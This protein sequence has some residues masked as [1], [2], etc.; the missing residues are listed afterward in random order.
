MQQE[1]D[2]LVQNFVAHRVDRTAE[3][4]AE[5]VVYVVVVDRVAQEPIGHDSWARLA[6]TCGKR[7][8]LESGPR[9]A[10][11][12]NLIRWLRPTD[13]K[14]NGKVSRLRSDT[15]VPKASVCD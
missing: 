10:R 4:E 6:E 9:E 14:L 12:S 7:A 3:L 15:T 8:Q 13:R 11:R 1:C 5:N 2:R